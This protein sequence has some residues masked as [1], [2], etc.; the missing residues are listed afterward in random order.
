[1]LFLQASSLLASVSSSSLLHLSAA[2][3]KNAKNAILG[4]PKDGKANRQ[5]AGNQ[6]Q[7]LSYVDVQ[8]EDA[9]EGGVP[10][11]VDNVNKASSNPKQRKRKV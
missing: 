6:D 10:L 2:K 11:E 1:M 3:F 5:N 7:S 4:R 8:M 9:Q